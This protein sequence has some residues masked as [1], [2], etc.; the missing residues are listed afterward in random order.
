MST[1]REV[2]RSVSKAGLWLLKHLQRST[3]PQVG[4]T[5][6]A[7]SG[8]LQCSGVE[9]FVGTKTGLLYYDGQRLL[10]FFEGRVYGI[11]YYAGR[12]YVAWNHR[13][14]LG[15]KP[16]GEMASIISF[17]FVNGHVEDLKVDAA[18]LDEEVH[19]IDAWNGHV[20]VTDTA[21]N[22][23]LAFRREG[24]DLTYETAYYP[25]GTLRDG[26][27][28]PN[29][30]HI[31]SV[32]CNGGLIYLMYH[33]QTEK[34]GRGS[35]VAVLQPEW[36]IEKIIKT[37]GNSAHNVY[38]EG[39]QVVFCDSMNGRL[40][41][42][43]RSLMDVDSYMRGLAVS[44]AFWLVGGSEHAKRGERGFTDGV[45]YQYDPKHNETVATMEIPGCGSLY[46]IRLITP[47]DLAIS[48]DES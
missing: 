9:F 8:R 18:P 26:K 24:D 30:A 5:E 1:I 29:Y 46:E 38:R 41:Q 12:W 42:G 3:L 33:N 39:D 16:L 40:M 43:D 25:N 37:S 45:I 20:Y 10:R 13:V 28:S 22:R 7:Y 19:Q 21:H 4:R 36:E 2:K 48:T 6:V 17:R 14:H 31:N 35:E 23:V 32:F 44:E 27:A 11:S 47:P 15:E 34:T